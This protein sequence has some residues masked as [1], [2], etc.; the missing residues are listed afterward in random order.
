MMD[1]LTKA[2]L[3]FP[4]METLDIHI[5][6][7]AELPNLRAALSDE[8]LAMIGSRCPPLLKLNLEDCKGVTA[9]NCTSLREINLKRCHQVSASSYSVLS[10]S[11]LKPVF[12][13]SCNDLYNGL[14]GFSL[15]N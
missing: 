7:G 15:H 3:M 10:S 6:I 1:S 2:A 8:G 12:P 9:E 4:N 14:R 5:G 11:S 13:P